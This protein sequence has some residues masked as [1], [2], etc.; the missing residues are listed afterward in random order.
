MINKYERILNILHN[1]F[2]EINVEIF[3]NKSNELSIGNGLY[4]E[5][6]NDEFTLENKV[7]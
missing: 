1:E 4:Y 6:E 2:Y 5:R 7:T 3:N